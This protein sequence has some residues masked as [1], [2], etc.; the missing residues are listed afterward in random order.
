VNQ[1]DSLVPFSLIIHETQ[2]AGIVTPDY[3]GFALAAGST[4]HCRANM[5]PDPVALSQ[6]RSR[7]FSDLY[8]ELY[9]A[10]SGSESA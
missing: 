8:F 10:I 5:Y 9:D 7:A 3:H 1:E 2:T 6:N 4:K